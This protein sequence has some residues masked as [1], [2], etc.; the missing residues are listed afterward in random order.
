MKRTIDHPFF[1][2][3]Q[4]DID[5]ADDKADAYRNIFYFMRVSLIGIAGAI[6]IISGIKGI[7][8]TSSLTTTLILGAVITALTSIDTLFQI[9]TKKN[10]YKLIHVELREIRSDMLFYYDELTND[11]TK[12]RDVK[13]KDRIDSHFFP[14]Y[15]SVM[16]YSKTLIEK[17]K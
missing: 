5:R 13:L 15:K 17:D 8:E 10:T 7:A 3:V 12:D 2:Q 14:K 1:I 16:A 4:D 11:I 6:T 9:E